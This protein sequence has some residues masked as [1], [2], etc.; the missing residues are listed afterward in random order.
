MNV[1]GSSEDSAYELNERNKELNCIYGVSELLNQPDLK[2]D[3][4]MDKILNLIQSAMEFPHLT[5]VRIRSR[6]KEY[7]SLDFKITAWEISNKDLVGLDDVSIEVYYMEDRPFTIE[8][9]NLLEEVAFR[10]KFFFDQKDYGK[11][12]EILNKT[13]IKLED[14]ERKFRFLYENAPLA[15][16]S[17]DYKGNILDVNNAWLNFLGYEKDEV[18]GKWFGDF[19]DHEYLK[20]LNTRFPKFKE[21]GEVKGVEYDLIKKDGSHAMVSF[22]G[23]IG[24]DENMNFERTHC[25]FQDITEQKMNEEKLKLSEKRFKRIFEAIPDL[26]FLVDEKGTH[27]DFKGNEELLYLTPDMFLGKSIKETMPLNVS[28]KYDKAIRETLQT[29]KPSIFEYKLPI[30]DD[31]HYFEA[32]N[33]YFSKDQVAIFV[34]DVTNR[35]KMEM[36]LIESEDQLKILNKELE[37]KIVERTQELY[38]S[39]NKYRELFN[40]MTSGVAIYNATN[41]GEDFIFKDLNK[42]GERI[43]QVEKDKIL[44]R[45]VN[46]V[47]PGVKDLG[48]F[49]IFK[50]VWKTGVP[51]YF[52][53]SLYKDEKISHW[54]ENYVYK[55]PTGEIIAVYNDVTEKKIAELKLKESEEKFRSIFMNSPIGIELYDSEGKLIDVNQA[56]L[57][58]FGAFDFQS[59][60][61]FDLFQDPNVSEDVKARLLAGE[62]L[63]YESDFDFGKVKELNLYETTKSGIID[64][65]IS[66]TPLYQS[67]TN[68]ISNYLVQVQD[69]SDKKNAERELKQ[70]SFELEF[71]VEERTQELKE[72]E[73]KY[74]SLADELEIILDHI[75]GIVVYKDTE[76]NMLR[77]NKFMADAHNLKK[78]DMEGKSS[79]EFYPYEEAQAYWEDDLEV[80]RSK[81]PKFNIVEPWETL[82][83]RRWVNTSK[84]PYI[85]ED[86]NVQGVIAIAQ[87]ITE[88]KLTE[89]NLRKSEEKYRR[90]IED[91]TVGVWLIDSEFNTKLVNPHMAEMLGY[92]VEEM[93]GKPL[94]HFMTEKNKDYAFHNLKL[95]QEGAIHVDIEFEFLHKSGISTFTQLK[96]STIFDADGNFEGAFAFITD[97]TEKK[98]TLKALKASEAKFRQFLENF[99]GIAYQTTPLSFKPNFFYGR[100]KEISG[101]ES[102]EF[103]EGSLTWDKIIH[104]ADM[105]SMIEES[106]KVNEVPNYIP[107]LEYRILRK[108]G[109]IRW[110]RDTGRWLYN[111]LGEKKIFQGAIYDI[112]ISK[113]SEE[114]IKN[115]NKFLTNVIESLTHPFYV[116]NVDDYTIARANSASH[117]GTRTEHMKCHELTHKNKSPCQDEHPC[118]ID[119]VKNN[120][121]Q[122][123]LEHIHYDSEG[124]ARTIEMHGYPILDQ[125]GNVVQLI[126][127]NLDIT[128]RKKAEEELLNIKEF[129]KNLLDGLINGVWVTDEEDNINYVNKGMEKIAGVSADNIMGINVLTD[130]PKSTLKYFRLLYLEAKNS[131][132]PLYYEEIPVT[133]PA[134]RDSFQSGW[135]IPRVKNNFYEGMIC[136]VDDVTQRRYAEQKLKESEEQFRLLAEQA[137]MGICIAQDNRIKYINKA[138][139]DIWGYSVEEMMKWDLKKVFE[140]IHPEDREFALDQLGKKQK[141]E[142]DIV[143]H[144]QYRGFTK[145]ND[146]I[147]VDQYSKSIL[148]KGKPANFVTLVN[149]TELKQAEQRIKE[150]EEKFSKAFHSSPTL[151]AITRMEDGNFLDVNDT[152]VKTLGYSRE[153]LIDHTSLKLN[154]WVHPDQRT[155]F[156]R[157]L[158]E[159][160]RIEAFDV[161]V[162]TKSGKI[163]TMLFSGDIIYLNSEPHLITIATDITDRIKAEKK[164]KESELRYRS[165]FENMNAAFAYHKII[166][167]EKNNPIDYEFR[168]ANSAFEEFTGLKVENIIGKTVKEVLPGIE[169]DPADWI[170][171]YGK[172]ALTGI[173]IT[174]ENYAEP[175]DQWYSVSAYSPKKDY[176]AVTFTNITE[177]KKVLS[178]LEK[179]EANWRILVED[180]PDIILTVDRNCR[181]LFIN[182]PPDGLSSEQVIGTNVIDYVDPEYHEVVQKSITRVFET[183]EP[184]HYEI[185]ARGPNDS[186][187]WY[188]TRLGAIKQEGEIASVMLITTDITER[189]KAEEEL[190]IKNYALNSSINAIAISDLAGILTFVNPSFLKMWG[191]SSESEVIGKKTNS[192][193]ASEENANQVIMYLKNKHSWSGELIGKKKDGKLFDSFLSASLVMDKNGEQ[194]CMMAT[195]LDITERKRVEQLIIEE[196]RKLKELSEMKRDIITRVSHELKTPLTSIHGA[197]YYLLNYHKDNMTKEI[198]EYLEIIHRGGL[199]L[200]SLVD[201]LIDISRLESGKLELKKAEVNITT[202]IM[203]CL[204]D[205]NYF[206]S[207][208]NLFIKLEMPDKLLIEVDKIR[209]GQ[210]ISNILSNAIKNTPPYGQ[211]SVILNDN[212]ENVSIQIKDT[213]VGITQEEKSLLFKKFGKIER[214]GKGMDVDTEGSGLGLFISKEIVE[215]HNGDIIFESEGRNLGA[216]FT[217]ILPKTLI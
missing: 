208:R 173:P 155:E 32:R 176:F 66:I 187:S 146:L 67:G 62:I 117:F 102:V 110:V 128:D 167:D 96:A 61:S 116:I 57:D 125:E 123:T 192:F 46:E 92:K 45:N 28:E 141:G 76:N 89:D 30:G 214:Y 52:P 140:V 78:V 4:T 70:A 210:V 47:F 206:A 37:Q 130:F 145:S 132:K 100:V 86:G 172:V 163:L 50:K 138:Y 185:S 94:F 149:I 49:D 151:M 134:G 121:K 194:I 101:Y 35:K 107:N 174:F 26:F 105:P 175:L 104:P 177:R 69:I 41:D 77:V 205:L 75:P 51:E 120:K 191:Y 197:S 169:K 113:E 165:L 202:V 80:I 212:L 72:S 156:T 200:K 216:I 147:W 79:F 25:I 48:L 144:Y 27:L 180:A 152:Y 209:I 16:Q 97:I 42:A 201:D 181:I 56:C 5:S 182:N 10:L 88:M 179:S 87:D 8:K 143:I 59:V 129:Y 24:Y 91:T 189:M 73:E 157:R 158:K 95:Q 118:P 11:Q 14:S 23:K 36:K 171:K 22:N 195:F 31:I 126:E 71:K 98:K 196:N 106:K 188:S 204:Q 108:D 133:T 85:N 43:S 90:L 131:L 103:V 44:E 55:L 84:I 68:S 15:Y 74:R 215:L 3:E 198:L 99:E 142:K 136:T 34:R 21:E 33:L 193:W 17:L 164:R 153:E 65:D 114:E 160:K 19:V 83:G 190:V 166:V 40:N 150:S 93:I 7:Q 159:N 127:Y 12:L 115:Q 60:K 184:D 63:K 54:V 122:V 170:S 109:E 154:L 178:E 64:L 124:N 183:G 82:E 81:T 39:E 6:K 18:I 168:E 112:T 162:Y 135:L 119:I 9:V 58:I 211:I 38:E 186:S 20:V 13:Q 213:G 161:D 217:I 139:A 137:L 199:R 148:Y 203:D 53:T 1:I 207:H 111:Q 2:L 29:H